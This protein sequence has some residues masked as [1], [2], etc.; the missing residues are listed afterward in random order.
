M[1]CNCKK[2]SVKV[3][4]GTVHQPKKPTAQ[5]T[6]TETPKTTEPNHTP[7]KGNNNESI[8]SFYGV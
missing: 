1:A 3:V 2:K 6:R 4:K 7:K 8:Y 5:E